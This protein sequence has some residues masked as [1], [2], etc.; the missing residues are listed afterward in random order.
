MASPALIFDTQAAI[1]GVKEWAEFVLAAYY[2]AAEIRRGRRNVPAN[3]QRQ[4]TVIPTTAEPVDE[5]WTDAVET[6]TQANVVRLDVATA[7]AG[8]YRVQVLGQNADYVAGVLDT[9]TTI[10]DG[11]RSAVDVLALAVTT[12]DIGVDAFS[13]TGNVAGVWLGVRVAAVPVVDALVMTV[14]DDVTRRSSSQWST[15]TLRITIDDIRPTAAGASAVTPA[16]QFVRR[17]LA[18]ADVPVVNGSAVVY[19]NDYLSRVGLAVLSI[20]PANVADYQAGG[21][22]G[23]LWRERA[24]IDVVFNCVT[25]LAFDIPTIETIEPPVLTAI[26]I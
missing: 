14:V 7:A 20:G 26:T 22:S 16:A 24:V 2:S 23:P 15:W 10:R 9:L 6:E 4:V 1:T 8:L 25:G 12:A 13:I 5:G 19:A 17:F 21:S 18:A 11:L 3:S